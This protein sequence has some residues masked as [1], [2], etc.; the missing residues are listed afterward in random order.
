MVHSSSP[1][2]EEG[3]IVE[4]N[5]SSSSDDSSLQKKLKP[6]KSIGK[7][8]SPKLTNKVNPTWEFPEEPEDFQQVYPGVAWASSSHDELGKKLFKD[9]KDLTH[10]SDFAKYFPRYSVVKENNRA[11]HAYARRRYG[12][13]VTKSSVQNSSNTFGVSDAVTYGIAPAVD[14]EVHEEQS[15]HI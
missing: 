3:E 4:S 14:A 10:T 15:L 6:K 13:F 5:S 8:R 9:K 1:A 7:K 11:S 2:V 12:A